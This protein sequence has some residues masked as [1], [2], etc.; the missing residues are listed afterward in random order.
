MEKTAKNIRNIKAKTKEQKKKHESTVEST[1]C[2]PWS[3]SKSYKLLSL[4]Y[5]KISYLNQSPMG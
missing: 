4:R 3:A 1:V 2:G 5:L